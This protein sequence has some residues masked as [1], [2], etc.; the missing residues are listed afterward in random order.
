MMRSSFAVF[1]GIVVLTL[2]TFAIE[3]ATTALLM[4]T[5]PSALPTEE[6][7]QRN[8]PTKLFILIYS[9]LCM[10]AA[11]YI[12]AWIAPR[13][14]LRLAIIMAAIQVAL[15]AWAMAA[16]YDHA[17]LWAWLA[18]MV[19][20][21]PAAWLGAKLRLNRKARLARISPVT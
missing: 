3:A 18:G 15:T 19:L 16:F 7:L 2:L 13:N 14:E 4:N 10:I 11:G 21:V 8:V 6:A 5:F 17:P 9:T 12:T 1:T 20:M